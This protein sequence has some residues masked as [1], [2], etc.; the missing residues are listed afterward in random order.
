[1]SALRIFPSGGFFSDIF[2]IAHGVFPVDVAVGAV[3]GV[4]DSLRVVPQIVQ[5]AAFAQCVVRRR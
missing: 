4:G 1:M 2:N 3:D 5:I